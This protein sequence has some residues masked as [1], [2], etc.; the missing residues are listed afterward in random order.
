V[1]TNDSTQWRSAR[2]TYRERY[3]YFSAL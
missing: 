2:L 3:P 1:V